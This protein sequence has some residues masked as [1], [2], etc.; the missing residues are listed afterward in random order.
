MELRPVAVEV[1]SAGAVAS[2][3]AAGTEV[4]APVPGTVL[5]ITAVVAGVLYTLCR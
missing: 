4:K 2:T 5:R 3:P 1:K